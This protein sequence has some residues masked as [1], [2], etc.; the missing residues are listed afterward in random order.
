MTDKTILMKDPDGN[1][2][3]CEILSSRLKETM[4]QKSVPFLPPVLAGLLFFLNI[5]P[6]L[7]TFIGALTVAFGAKTTFDSKNKVYR[8]RDLIINTDN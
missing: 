4:F 2:V 6:G 5:C 7:G 1:L 8:K 3:E